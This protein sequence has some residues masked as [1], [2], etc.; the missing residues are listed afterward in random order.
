MPAARKA[1][2]RADM[3]V[4]AGE[5]DGSATAACF[6]AEARA[7]GG[8]GR[9]GVAGSARATSAFSRKTGRSGER[10]MRGGR[11]HDPGFFTR[12]RGH[13]PWA[14]LLRTRFETAAKRYG[15]G[16]SKFPLRTD[17]F[18]PPAGDQM[19]LL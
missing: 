7:P 8:V 1:S 17:L 9:A 11:D 16:Q 6:G 4:A 18:E 13:G 19:R 14:E 12:M 15:L 10:S 3:G 5:S 2:A